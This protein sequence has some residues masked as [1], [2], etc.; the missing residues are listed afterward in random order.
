MQQINDWELQH[1]VPKKNKGCDS[2][3]FA[4]NFYLHTSLELLLIFYFFVSFIQSGEIFRKSG[5][6]KF[7]LISEA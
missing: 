6:R 3:E 1:S 2:T 4:E 5:L 7:P